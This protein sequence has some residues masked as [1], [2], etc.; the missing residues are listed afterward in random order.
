[1][2]AVPKI[3]EIQLINWWES[4]A[5]EQAR[6]MKKKYGQSRRDNEG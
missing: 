6:D 4:A 1:M 5:G 3:E 2:A